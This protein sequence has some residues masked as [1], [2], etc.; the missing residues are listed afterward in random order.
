MSGR[1]QF[2]NSDECMTATAVELEVMVELSVEYGRRNIVLLLNATPKELGFC[3]EIILEP[4]RA[5]GP[6]E[7]GR[8]P[9]R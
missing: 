9:H 5:K 7:E 8:S 3:R 2:G 6:N 1:Q 4:P